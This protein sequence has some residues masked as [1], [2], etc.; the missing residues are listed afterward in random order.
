MEMPW[1]FLNNSEG[2]L[3]KKVSNFLY[4]EL[5]G[6][7]IFFNLTYAT[8]LWTNRLTIPLQP[9]WLFNMKFDEDNIYAM[10]ISGSFPFQSNQR[11]ATVWV[12]YTLKN[13][14]L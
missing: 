12:V 3:K 7:Y 5:L 14:Q 11:L 6:L 10:D 4:Y 13:L 9:V 8:S 1:K 2:D